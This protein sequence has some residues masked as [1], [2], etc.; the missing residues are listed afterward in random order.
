MKRIL[1]VLTVFALMLGACAKPV[2]LA[3]TQWQLINIDGKNALEDVLVTLNFSDDAIGGTDGCNSYGGSYTTD[4]DKINFEDDIFST[5][6]NCP[7]KIMDQTLRY[8]DALKRVTNYMA[9][10][11]LL[12]LFDKD[13]RKLAE[14]VPYQE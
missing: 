3:D 1:F 5:L 2:S 6:M 9:D 11:Q 13:G 8:Y 10:R 7:E 14:L 4:G 12:T